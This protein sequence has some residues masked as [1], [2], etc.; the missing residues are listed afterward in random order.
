MFLDISTKFTYRNIPKGYKGIVTQRIKWNV[1]LP[2]SKLCK[3]ILLEIFDWYAV[4]TDIDTIKEEIRTVV[5]WLQ[6]FEGKIE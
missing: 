1:K 6:D 4:Y 2:L 3:S 5:E